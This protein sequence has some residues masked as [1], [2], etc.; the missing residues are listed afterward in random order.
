[1]EVFFP[2]FPFLAILGQVLVGLAI[3]QIQNL[4]RLYAYIE[5]TF[6]R[7]NKQFDQTG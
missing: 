7:L 1:M 3:L 5:F 6:V 4:Y 2:N